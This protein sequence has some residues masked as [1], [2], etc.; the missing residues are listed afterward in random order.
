MYR[1]LKLIILS[2]FC[3]VFSVCQAADLKLQDPADIDIIYQLAGNYK[4][5]QEQVDESVRQISALEE[6]LE[7]AIDDD[8]RAEII[9]ALENAKRNLANLRMNLDEGLKAAY[10]ETRNLFPQFKDGIVRP[11]LYNPSAYNPESARMLAEA[12]RL[13]AEIR[14]VNSLVNNVDGSITENPIE[15]RVWQD[16]ASALENTGKTLSLGL[17]NFFIRQDGI[18]RQKPDYLKDAE[19][20]FSIGP[21]L[22]RGK[23]GDVPEGDQTY[24][25]FYSLKNPQNNQYASVS[26]SE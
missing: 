24:I 20:V 11:N 26:Y 10:G 15:Q 4:S 3:G 21:F 6:S 13:I 22:K 1:P 2:I 7:T 14:S 17:T 9:D 19:P 23:G 16:T 5:W 25:D 12:R 8:E 18:G